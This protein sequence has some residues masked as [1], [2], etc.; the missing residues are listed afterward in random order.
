MP[1]FVPDGVFQ[2][3]AVVK[4]GKV[5]LNGAAAGYGA[6]S[7]QIVHVLSKAVKPAVQLP[8]YGL[9]DIN[10]GRRIIGENSIEILSAEDRD[11]GN[12]PCNI[13]VTRRGS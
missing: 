12:L 11:I 8:A 3:T 9:E 6:P 2:K 13:I 4:T 7:N 5:V 1:E 10:G